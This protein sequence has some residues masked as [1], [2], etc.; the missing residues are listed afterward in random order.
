VDLNL[1]LLLY[2]LLVA[3]VEMQHSRDI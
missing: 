3:D 1:R 2:I